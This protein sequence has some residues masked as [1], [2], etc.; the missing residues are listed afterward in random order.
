MNAETEENKFKFKFTVFIGCPNAF[1][2]L[3]IRPPVFIKPILN[4]KQN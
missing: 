2:V 4:I 3:S 1:C